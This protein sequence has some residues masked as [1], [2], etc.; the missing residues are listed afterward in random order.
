MNICG[1]EAG[2]R[3]STN[4]SVDT[5]QRRQTTASNREI[6]RPAPAETDT[7]TPRR[8]AKTNLGRFTLCAL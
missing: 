4:N 1:D 5:E 7:R 3:A 8:N 6:Q 2:W